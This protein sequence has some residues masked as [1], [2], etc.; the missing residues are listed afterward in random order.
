MQI[1]QFLTLFFIFIFPLFASASQ[2]WRFLPR[3]R[4]LRF[5][6]CRTS[7]S[8]SRVIPVDLDSFSDSVKN[9]LDST[10]RIESDKSVPQN[11]N[12]TG[13]GF[14]DPRRCSKRIKNESF[15]L[16]SDITF[17]KCVKFIN[18]GYLDFFIFSIKNSFETNSIAEYQLILLLE[19]SINVNKPN[20]AKVLFEMFPK[21]AFLPT[22][23]IFSA[24]RSRNIVA[25]NLILENRKIIDMNNLDEIGFNPL[26]KAAMIDF[27]EGIQI[28]TLTLTE[29]MEEREIELH[30]IIKLI[31]GS[32]NVAIT[33]KTLFSL[34]ELFGQLRKCGK[35]ELLLSSKDFMQY[36][37]SAII[38]KDTEIL[39]LILDN[40]P[41]TLYKQPITSN[42]H[43]TL[44]E[45]FISSDFMEGFNLLLEHFGKDFIMQRDDFGRTPFLISAIYGNY[46]FAL[47]I[48]AV[49]PEQIH[50]VDHHGNNAYHLVSGNKDSKKSLEFVEKIIH[51]NINWGH[52]NNDRVVPIELFCD[53]NAEKIDVY[54]NLI[55]SNCVEQSIKRREN[56]SK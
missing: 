21:L 46:G 55:F 40:T 41:K 45:K 28:M 10:N 14:L 20:F 33:Y 1:S 48:A 26:E 16:D 19:H 24:I 17:D 15:F 38:E 47:K 2:R 12:Q 11:L 5:G 44:I 35:I 9:D 52:L 7:T 18:D 31:S 39:K 54:F 51:L 56:L 49:D 4:L 3:R 50:S 34:K 43:N 22:N 32:I 27:V 37:N 36:I 29:L 30:R 42:L 53:K 23:V 8:D 13:L 25:L 6:L